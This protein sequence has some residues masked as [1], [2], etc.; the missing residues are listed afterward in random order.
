MKLD[1]ERLKRLNDFL[2][3]KKSGQAGPFTLDIKPTNKCNLNCIFCPTKSEY[4]KLSRKELSD[5]QYITLIKDAVK[6]GVKEIYI[7]GGGEPLIRKNLF[8]KL[9]GLI[10]KNNI[11]GI[12]ITNG[13]LFD[14]ENIKKIIES[15]WDD[16]F[17]SLDGAT[18]NTNN[19]LRAKKG[20]FEKVI[21]NLVLF[22]KIKKQLGKEKPVLHISMV[23]VNK[24]YK[25]LPEMIKLMKK[26][27][28]E[29]LFLQKFIVWSDKSRKLELNCSQ[30]KELPIYFEK[31]KKLAKEHGIATNLN[32][33][34]NI[35]LGSQKNNGN[36]NQTCYMPFLYF[37]VRT[38]GVVQPCMS[39]SDIIIGDV[40]KQS[41]EEIWHGQKMEKFRKTLLSRK[42]HGFCETCCAKMTNKE[43][44]DL[45][46]K[47]G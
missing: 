32:E 7:G 42:K 40:S 10:K 12:L 15:N 24:N 41:P 22:N 16:I 39:K 30:V 36:N 3:G 31:A 44:E 23:L 11:R 14:E 33:F 37:C 35:Y 6:A 20:A 4:E 13:T 19:Y 8:L 17:F 45:K 28:V 1:D 34:G 25:E 47:N 46:I 21:N 5:E 29:S 2:N 27:N 43:F 18:S 38:D 9:V 26:H